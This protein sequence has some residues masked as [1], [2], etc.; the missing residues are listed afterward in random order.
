M[1]DHA[2]HFLGKD[3][4]HPRP[5]LELQAFFSVSISAI[6]WSC[7]GGNMKKK[8]GLS[9]AIPNVYRVQC[10]IQSACMILHE[11][12]VRCCESKEKL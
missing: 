6:S 4:Q 5:T 8:K 10:M 9:N 12:T 2:D 7:A 3:P 1:T 11:Q